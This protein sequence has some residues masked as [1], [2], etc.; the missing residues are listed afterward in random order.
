MEQNRQTETH[1][2]RKL[3]KQRPKRETE[4]ATKPQRLRTKGR[5]KWRMARP[6]TEKRD[7]E[8]GRSK[9]KNCI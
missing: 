6:M 1:T 9:N 8:V 5:Q 3:E 4:A 7:M 2:L